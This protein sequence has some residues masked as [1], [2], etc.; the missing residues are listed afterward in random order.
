MAKRDPESAYQCAGYSGELK[1]QGKN[2]VGRCPF[3]Q[4]NKPS[5]G[6]SL[7][8]DK[9]G[10]FHCFGCG[11]GGS[12][13]DFVKQ[14]QNLTTD[15]EAIERAG[16]LLGAGS[17][18]GA[19]SNNPKAQVS[20]MPLEPLP[21]E[22]AE[23]HHQTLLRCPRQ[24]PLFKEK[25][26]LSDEMIRRAQIGVNADRFTIPVWYNGELVDI[27]LYKLRRR[28]NEP[29]M[30]PREEGRGQTKV[31]GWDWAADEDTVVLAEGEL[32]ALALLDRGIAAFSVTNGA[33]KWPADPPD[34]SG[35]AIYLCGDADEA[36][37]SMNE[38]LPPKLYAAGAA[39]VRVIEWPEDATEGYDPTDYFKAGGTPEGFRKLMEGARPVDR[40]AERR[41]SAEVKSR[42]GGDASVLRL[43]CDETESGKLMPNCVRIAEY[44]HDQAP[45]FSLGGRLYRYDNGVYRPGAEESLRRDVAQRLGELNTQHR[46]R[47]I[48][49]YARDKYS[50]R[51]EQI[52]ANPQILNVA[53][54]LLN[55]QTLELSA[56]DPQYLSTVQ[57]PVAYHQDARCPQ[58]HEFF[59]E[60]FPADCPWLGYEIIGYCL[61][62]DLE[63]RTAILLLGPTHSGKTTLISLLTS[64]VGPHNVVNVELHDFGED[65]SAAAQLFGKM[66]NTFA[67]LPSTPL[68]RSSTFKALTG[69]DRIS[70]Q[71]KYGQPFEF[72]SYAKLVFSANQAPGTHD[73]SDAYYHRWQVIPFVNQFLNNDEDT[74]LLAKLTTRQELEGLLVTAMHA[75]MIIPSTGRL[76]TPTSVREAITEFRDTTDTVAAFRSELC[77][78]GQVQTVGK[79]RLYS[80][81]KS[82]C[83]DNNLRATSQRKFNERLMQL[84]PDI[85]ETTLRA[86]SG[87]RIKSWRGIGIDAEK[88]D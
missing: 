8:G 64:L 24:L 73:H 17:A 1:K 33:G 36:G 87:K 20:T 53:N 82:W 59:E 56:H 14:S 85:Q 9:V 37:R 38:S 66:V 88:D 12:I 51:A 3:H 48:V 83:E 18:P 58:I 29:P 74:E 69:G 71:F 28:S 10:C 39:Q 76:S 19:S 15:H 31:C 52:D 60:V 7:S 77:T 67:D 72:K 32:D 78:I 27:R 42:P 30:L 65:R 35:K 25:R 63:P 50:V 40:S 80:T 70:A 4:D 79:Q 21:P 47:E 81:Y 11:A 34:L 13:I 75:T 61:R 2:L 54:G 16:E 86:S 43:L 84:V 49:G 23:K 5:F 44:L 62:R 68:R 45:V 55:V 57:I 22:L 6:I 26:A 41:Q 46:A